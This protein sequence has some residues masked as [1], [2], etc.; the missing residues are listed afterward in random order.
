M[1]KL[2][3]ATHVEI[4]N[5]I[6]QEDSSSCEILKERAIEAKNKLD[7]AYVYW[8]ENDEDFDDDRKEMMKP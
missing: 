8:N 5:F 1:W 6:E 4:T 7:Q 2:V 3:G